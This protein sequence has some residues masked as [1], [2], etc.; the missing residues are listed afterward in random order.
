[1]PMALKNSIK[2]VPLTNIDSST[3]TTLYKAINIG[4]LPN[5]CFKI[6]I[7]NNSSNDVTVSYDGTNDHDYIPKSTSIE[8]SG[9]ANIPQ[10]GT[11]T[12]NTVVYVKGTAGTGNIYLSG[13]YQ[14][15]GI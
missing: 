6:R 8:I 2:A 4:G 3:V 11:F 7:I 5:P 13:Y 14:P 12:A 15:Q 1:M 10:F 9:A